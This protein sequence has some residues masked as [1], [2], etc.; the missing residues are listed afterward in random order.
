MFIEV[1]AMVNQLPAK[2]K[3]ALKKAVK[4]DP[5][6]VLFADVGGLNKPFYG[7]LKDIPDGVVLTVVGPDPWRDRRWYAS[8]KNGKVT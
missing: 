5:D 3:T 1:Q 4:E 8:V 7:G 6:S 2:T